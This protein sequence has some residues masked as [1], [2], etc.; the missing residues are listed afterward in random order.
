[1]QAI[2]KIRLSTKPMIEQTKPPVAIPLC[3]GFFLPIAPKTIPI[4]A[5]IAP[6]QPT[7]PPERDYEEKSVNKILL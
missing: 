5:K 4:I 6:N 2:Y 7:N 1:M 3:S